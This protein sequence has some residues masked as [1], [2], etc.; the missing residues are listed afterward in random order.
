MALPPHQRSGKINKT[1]HHDPTCTQSAR[2]EQ[3]F[4]V[5]NRGEAV[6]SGN[7]YLP[8]S[9]RQAKFDAILSQ[10]GLRCNRLPRVVRNAS[11]S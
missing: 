4:V 10:T 1:I 7:Q 11:R 8:R 3:T 2:F 5:G 6:L 9:S